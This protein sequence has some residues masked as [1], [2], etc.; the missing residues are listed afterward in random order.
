MTFNEE[1]GRLNYK[2][3]SNVDEMF[4]YLKAE[5]K[6][7]HDNF[8]KEELVN[9]V[10]NSVMKEI[11]R[12]HQTKEVMNKFQ[13]IMSERL[14]NYSCQDSKLQES[15]PLR[16]NIFRFLD[17]KYNVS[18]FVE[19]DRLKI[20]KIDGFITDEECEVL[21][22]ESSDQL[23]QA[24]ISDASGRSVISDNRKALHATHMFLPE[25]LRPD[26]LW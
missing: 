9:C 10:T 24:V 26:P 14:R 25:T 20:W 16:W 13:L 6:L 23:T 3:I 2:Q 19:S 4:D 21:L 12:L 15:T 5:T 8:V 18:H 17:R 1:E 7:C 11:Q 22:G